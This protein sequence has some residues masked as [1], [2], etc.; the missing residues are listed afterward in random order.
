MN[1]TKEKIKLK[2]KSLA[3]WR[4]EYQHECFSV[5][6]LMAKTKDLFVK[7]EDAQKEINEK[8]KSYAKLCARLHEQVID[9]TLKDK[10]LKHKLQQIVDNYSIVDDHGVAL[11][12]KRKLEELLKEAE[13]P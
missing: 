10:E 5:A 2:A 11:V 12:S 1:N 6:E 13:K 9:L 4:D 3:T 7:L 8:S